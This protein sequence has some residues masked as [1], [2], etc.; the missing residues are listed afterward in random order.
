MKK[1]TFLLCGVKNKRRL[2]EFL[3][4][5]VDF[6]ICAKLF[7]LHYVFLVEFLSRVTRIL[8]PLPGELCE[9][10]P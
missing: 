5:S 8:N 7:G 2:V 6:L 9:P 1:A 10:E 4:P 3:F